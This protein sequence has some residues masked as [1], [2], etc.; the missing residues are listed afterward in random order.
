MKPGLYIVSTPIGNL[1][2]ITLRALDILKKSDI[3]FCENTKHSMKLLKH[4]E[5]NNAILEKY[6]DHDFDKK[7]IKIKDAISSGKIISLISDAGAPLISDPGGRLIK[8]LFEEKL[9]IETI[10]GP[11]SIISAIQLSGFFNSHPIIFLGFLPKKEAQKVKALSN[12]TNANLVFFTTSSQLNKDIQVI[13]NHDQDAKIVILN[14]ITKKF[15]KRISLKKEEYEKISPI[16]LKGEFVVCAELN[17]IKIEKDITD[18]Q[19]KKDIEKFG[20]KNLY[21]IYR[22][23]YNIKRNDLYKKILKI[24]HK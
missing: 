9:N 10:P 6:T 3:I 4:F 12:I 21:E 23:K 24:K 1:G 17:P 2:D 19:V 20:E 15:E 14:E 16:V 18:D 5:I 22:S 7:H 11:S 13:F 8:F